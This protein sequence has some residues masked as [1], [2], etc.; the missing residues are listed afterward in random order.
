MWGSLNGHS[1]CP[2][3]SRL[4]N[5]NYRIQK[6]FCTYA[7]YKVPFYKKELLSHIIANEYEFL[8]AY[9]TEFN[10]DAG[11]WAPGL[12]PKNFLV[13]PNK[14]LWIPFRLAT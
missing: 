4:S 14:V 8:N 5:Y 10:A 1:S 12:L 13:T 3:S 6:E 9:T 7:V 2:E 11:F